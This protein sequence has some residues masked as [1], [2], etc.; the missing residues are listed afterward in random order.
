M[1]KFV[2]M[3]EMLRITPT[4]LLKKSRLMKKDAGRVGQSK[5]LYWPSEELS[6]DLSS[7]Q[8]LVQ[9]LEEPSQQVVQWRITKLASK[10]PKPQLEE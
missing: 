8:F 6:Q 10:L 2:K 1:T 4:K 9:L 7:A 5:L 3:L